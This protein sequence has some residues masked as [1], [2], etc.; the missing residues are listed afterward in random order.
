MPVTVRDVYRAID[1]FAPFALAEEW[2]NAGILAGSE[3]GEVRGILCA[4]DLNPAVIDEAK[5]LGANLIVTHHPILFRGR[6][7]LR[8][9][10]AE[11]RALCALVR[12]GIALIAAHTNFDNAVPG[13]NDALA[14]RLG[15]EDVVALEQG[16]RVGVPHERTL[17]AFCDRASAALGAPVRRYGEAEREIRRVA[18]LGGA[19]GDFAGLAREAG[20]DVYLTGEIA[21]HKAWDAY[22]S[23]VCVLEAGHAATELPAVEMLAEGLQKTADGVKWNVRVYAS[24][25]ELFR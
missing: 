18:V 9:D 24:E 25:V 12:S 4:L 2:D 13:V 6:K 14:D 8:E 21:H 7:N 11:G 19:G 23:G 16:M 3:D 17:G 1:A 10:D 22:L 15:L 20:A 5:R